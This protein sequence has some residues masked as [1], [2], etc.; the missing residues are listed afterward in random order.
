MKK[1]RILIPIDG[2]DF[3]RRILPYVGEF[4]CPEQNELILL[5]IAEE[6]QGSVVQD[7]PLAAIEPFVPVFQSEED[8]T[9]VQ[10]PVYSSREW[11]R[12]H[13][14]LKYELRKDAR[15]LEQAG[16]TVTIY[17][18]FGLPTREIPV[19]VKAKA[20]DL[21]AMTTH[22]RTGVE[23]LLI[24]SVAEEML[25]KASV[26]VLLLRPFNQHERFER[27]ISRN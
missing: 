8:V 4:F 22:G 6:P 7:A 13:S 25:R 12:I 23:R 15:L 3:S 18:W 10:H 1:H 27:E 5:R 21:I 20:I 11:D 14:T 9:R 17:V 26:P 24:G 19:F 2:S 16:Y